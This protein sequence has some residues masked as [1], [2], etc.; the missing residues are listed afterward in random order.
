MDSGCS[1]AEPVCDARS[2]PAKCAECVGDA[3]CDDGNDCTLDVCEDGACSGTTIRA[4]EECS[5]GYCNGVAGEETCGECIDDAPDGAVDLGCAEGAP[6]CDVTLIPARCTGCMTNADCDDGIECTT[7]TCNGSGACVRTPDDEVCPDSGDACQPNKCVAG[8]GC[9]LVDISESKELIVNGAFDAAGG[10]Q[11]A[12]T[13]N[14]AIVHAETDTPTLAHT[15]PRL[16]WMAGMAN[17]LAEMWSAP[18]ITVPEGTRSLEF[19]IYYH[20][21]ST[22]D[23]PD[24]DITRIALRTAE[25]DTEVYSIAE[26]ANQDVT[27]GWT[28]FST[29]VDVSELEADE[30]E[31]YIYSQTGDWGEEEFTDVFLDTASMVANICAEE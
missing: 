25:D 30:L 24:R 15:F 2:S 5:E 26:W 3:D 19:S 12:A 8:S 4:G 6:T 10:W 11:E 23:E 21:E 9:Q 7:D 22:I 28:L 31:L 27:S 1:D 18:P 17:D 16:A 14:Y 29:S 20:V 13:N